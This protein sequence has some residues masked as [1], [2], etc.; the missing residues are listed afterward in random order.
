MSEQIL[1]GITRS[2]Y[3]EVVVRAEVSTDTEPMFSRYGRAFVARQV[4]IEYTYDVIN[5]RWSQRTEVFGHTAPV[6]GTRPANVGRTFERDS[7]E[8]MPQWLI[9]FVRQQRPAVIPS[10]MHVHTD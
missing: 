2:P 10:H 3:A 4:E 7:T 8:G 5:A 6:D 1:T 9:D